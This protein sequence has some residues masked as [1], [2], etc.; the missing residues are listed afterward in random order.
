MNTN[1]IE[2]QPETKPGTRVSGFGF[3]LPPKTFIKEKIALVGLYY[4][5]L[6]VKGAHN[7]PSLKETLQTGGNRA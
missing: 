3:L 6:Y 1:K 5:P 4:Q 2:T 7:P